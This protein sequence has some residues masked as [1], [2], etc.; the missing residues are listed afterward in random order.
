[1]IRFRRLSA[2][3]AAALAI[4]GLD[5]PQSA[6]EELFGAL[7]AAGATRLVR[8]GGASAFDEGLLWL[9]SDGAAAQ[10]ELQLHGGAGTADGLRAWLARYGAIE[11]PPEQDREDI[12]HGFLS[13][14]T[15]RVAAARAAL[16][17]GAFATRLREL[18]ALPATERQRAAAA[19]LRYAAW[20]EALEAPPA[21]VLA[22]PPNAGKSTLLNAWL[23][24]PRA[25]VSPLAGTTRD[26]VRALV[27]IGPDGLAFPVQLVDTAGLW[28]AAQGVDAAAVAR[29][30]R[31]IA[32]AWRV[33]W[34]FDAA[35]PPDA[36]L[37]ETWRE[38]QRP[39]DLRLLHRIDLGETWQPEQ[40]LG[41]RWLRGAVERDGAALI[42]ALE[43]ALLAALGPAPPSDAV[44]PLGA[45]RRATLERLAGIPGV[46]DEALE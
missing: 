26:A 19:E 22:G 13:A 4:G 41:G 25:T 33:I 3:G 14:R 30:R 44:L 11:E 18:E 32:G 17:G 21:V 42:A 5:G 9:R 37:Q 43:G 23:R 39:A 38:L 31:A 7:P 35:S 20:A 29:S 45:Q 34:V 8:V 10:A 46:V 24:R 36:R 1:M 27:P 12:E 40:R 28:S 2:A 16:R 15:P 6:L